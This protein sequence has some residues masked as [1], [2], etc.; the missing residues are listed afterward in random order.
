MALVYLAFRLNYR[1]ARQWE[2]VRV[3]KGELRLEKVD[4][5]GRHRHWQAPTAWMKVEL[6][7][8]VEPTSRLTLKTHRTRWTL[9]G[10]LSPEERKSLADSLR[11]ALYAANR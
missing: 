2:R 4:I 10:F 8:P 1:R 7:E 6:A 9:G 3:T 5:Y 11:G